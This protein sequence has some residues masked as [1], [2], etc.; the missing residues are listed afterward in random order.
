M[1][2]FKPLSPSEYSYLWRQGL[3]LILVL[4][5]Y[6]CSRQID[7]SLLTEI[8]KEI[9]KEFAPD[10][11]VA[12]YDIDVSINQK[13]VLI[14]GETDQPK[15]LE[16]LIAQFQ[17]LDLEI[18]D[19]VSLLPDESVGEQ[20]YAVVSNSVANIRSEAKHSAEL[21]TQ[22][23]LGTG[24]KVLKIDGDFYLVQTPDKYIAWVDHGGVKLM[25]EEEYSAW[26]D[27]AKIIYLKTFGQ[28]YREEKNELET[29]GDLVLGSTLQLIATTED[30]H[31]VKYP[32]G[33]MG[34]VRKEEAQNYLQWISELRPTP[35]RLE[36]YARSMMGI[37]YLWGGTSSKGVDCSGFTK[38]TFLMNGF[39][40]P[41]DA[42]QQILAGKD[43]DPE[44]KFENLQKGDLMFF[45]KKATDSTRQ[46]V[47]HVAI[48][49]DNGRGEFIHASGRVRMGSIDPESE[50][51]DSF[52][53]NRYLGSRRYLGEKH[54]E[55]AP[56][57]FKN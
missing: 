28:V 25:S 5:F 26:N 19:R 35:E 47:T 16:R 6:S 15:A 33:R 12:I 10:R 56:M 55:I 37:P 4:S 13:T 11:R 2:I 3:T 22:A 8:N 36:L 7:P 32:D 52:N 51:F 40:I 27:S 44:L 38:T 31:K 30:Y 43:I 45:G 29:L 49:L 34:Y 23:I 21:A 53:K 50:W 24:L 18:E 41:R 9:Q 1:T 46:R 20:S 39:I 14:Q 42:S 48:W 17:K 54:P 57:Q